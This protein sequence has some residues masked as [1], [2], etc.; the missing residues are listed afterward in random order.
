[1][2]GVHISVL[3][4]AVE[5]DSAAVVRLWRPV[6]YLVTRQV[7][8]PCVVPLK[9]THFSAPRAKPFV[10]KRP[11]ATGGQQ[12]RGG[13]G[14]E[15][16]TAGGRGSRADSRASAYKAERSRKHSRLQHDFMT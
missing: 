5:P 16:A 13:G 14:G 15:G 12:A 3:E 2:R 4:S 10:P 11:T 1:M 8:P 6:Q 9:H 7:Y